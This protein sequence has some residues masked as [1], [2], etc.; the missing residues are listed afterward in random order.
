[1][2]VAAALRLSSNLIEGSSE[3]GLNTEPVKEVP[4]D[5]GGVDFSGSHHHE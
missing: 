2:T 3:S 1:M 4:G 5:A